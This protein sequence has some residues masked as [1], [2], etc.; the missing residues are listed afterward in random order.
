MHSRAPQRS[1]RAAHKR[2]F[3][4][5]L[6]LILALTLGLVPSP[7]TGPRVA[8]SAA[9]SEVRLESS[10]ARLAASPAEAPPEI[11]V[12][13][14]AAADVA[15]AS[16]AVRERGGQVEQTYNHLIQALVPV[17][18]LP[19]LADDGRVRYIRL[20]FEPLPTAIETEGALA[21]GA[22]EWHRSGLTG[23]GVRV[24]VLDTGFD[25]Y[26]ALIGKE[27][28]PDIIVRSFRADGQLSGRDN[29]NHGT[30][31]AEIIYDIAPGV[32]L[33]LV[34]F[35]TEVELGNAVDYLISERVDIIS[36]SVGYFVTGPGDGTGIINEIVNRGA[37]AGILWV[38]AAGNHAQ[39]HWMGPWRDTTGDNF[40]NF[41]TNAKVNTINAA[42]GD[43]ISVEL[44]W[45]DPWGASCNDYD[46]GLYDASLKLVAESTN[47]QTC[48][49]DPVERIHYTVEQ[50][51]LHYVTVQRRRAEGLSAQAGLPAQAG[52]NFF[53]LFSRNHSLFIF[54]PA[55][56]L[57]QPADNPHVVT[58]GAVSVEDGTTIELYSSRG[59]TT[60]RRLKPDLLGP[61]RVSTVTRLRF[62]G[63]SASAP[64]VAAAAALVKQAGP[65]LTNVQ[66]KAFL[67]THT[68]PLGQER[69]NND[70]GWGRLRLGSAPQRGPA[71]APITE[72]LA[73]IEGKYRAV[74]GYIPGLSGSSWQGFS[75]TAPAQAN[76]LQELRVGFGY[77]IN[78][79]EAATLTYSGHIWQL[80]PGWNLI[81]WY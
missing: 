31:G 6:T 38:V 28:P 24:A 77:W 22:P 68:V 5:T 45:D 52:R 13:V 59:P 23:R 49:Q 2:L 58:V 34:N 43:R 41:D 42:K 1:G 47:E 50:T 35:N 17:S 14:E 44:R 26:Q 62:L 30:A 81:G 69:P 18:A 51:G 3:I 80:L 66:L 7:Q 73:S 54:E 11:R 64:H 61:D 32:Q 37:R 72:Q 65:G 55:S 60:D 33:Y 29:D 48:R 53:H 39:R 67:L 21:I 12:I 56:S 78:A 15:A 20:P 75:P 8:L 71:N 9:T 36:F 4:I 70:A 10:L 74:F 57:T 79:T 40:L 19:V 16:A 46:L 25:N 63:T 76:D 27:L